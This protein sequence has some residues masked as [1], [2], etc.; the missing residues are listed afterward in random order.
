VLDAVKKYME[1]LEKIKLI[2]ALGNPGKEYEKTFHNA[3]KII[4]DFLA[5]ENAKWK[6]KNEFSYIKIKKNILSKSEKF[7]NESGLSVKSAISFFKIKPEEILL[8]HDDSDI[9]LGEY[10]ITF[11]Q[12]SA[13]HKGVE[14]VISNLKTKDFFR[15]KIG[16][17]KPSPKRKK[18]EEFVLKRVSLA[19]LK[20]LYLVAEDLMEKLR[21]KETFPEE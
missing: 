17:R 14:T 15:A 13:G 6:T 3:G 16:I 21:L 20:T 4:A 8:I 10:K 5:G 9:T 2:F 19:D 7:M 18:A 12:N 1:K 11:S